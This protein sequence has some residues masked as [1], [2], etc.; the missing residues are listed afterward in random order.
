LRPSSAASCAAVVCAAAM[1]AGAS[2]WFMA[3]PILRRS[4]P[5]RAHGLPRCRI[6]A[7]VCRGRAAPGRGGSPARPIATSALSRCGALLRTPG[8]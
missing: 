5:H 3:C 7:S 2:A 1:S 6:G 8:L 4:A